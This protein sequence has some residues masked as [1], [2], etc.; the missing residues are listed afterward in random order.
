[1]FRGIEA[2]CTA[3]GGSR[4]PFTGKALNLAGKPSRIGGIAAKALGAVVLVIG[5]S[6]ALGLGLLA[7]TFFPG[8][9]AA[10]AIGLP[11]GIITLTFGLAL[12]LGGRQLTKSGD[13][14]SLDARME[15]VRAL[16]A[17]RRG[18]VTVPAVARSLEVSEAEAE[19]LLTR[20][21]QQDDNVSV[22]VDDDGTLQY[23]FGRDALALRIDA[24]GAQRIAGSD[25]EAAREAAASDELSQAEQRRKRR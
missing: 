14:A 22:D 2:R 13:A 20:I 8:G 6:V 15:A 25:D 17:H 19:A 3:C 4:I 12:I 1:V 7:Q 24:L 21:A 10:L 23:L 9:F 11:I 18:V 5:S 16:V